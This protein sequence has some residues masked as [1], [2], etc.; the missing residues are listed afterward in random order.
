[1]IESIAMKTNLYIICGYTDL[2]RSVDGLSAMV[3][4]IFHEDPDES[5]AYFF[6]GRRCDR[7]K[8]L[9]R[10]PDGMCLLYKRLDSS[11]RG[12]FR[13][14]RNR[15]EVKEITWQQFE[16]LMSGLEIEQPKALKMA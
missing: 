6:C 5:S 3:R 16:W 14:P 15:N 10:D 9:I 1:M 12:R 8:V 4:E 11:V 7:F 13:W 2:R